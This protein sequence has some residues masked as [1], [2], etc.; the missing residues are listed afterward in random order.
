MLE[1]VAAT[2]NKDK[3]KEI[4]RI[5]KDLNVRVLTLDNF[6]KLPQVI[7]SGKTLEENASKKARV[8]SRLIKRFTIADDSGLEVEAL[9]GRPGVR[10][11]RFAGNKASYSE[12]NAKLLRMLK[13]LPLSKRKAGFACAVSIAK[14]GKVLRTVRGACS[15]RI[16]FTLKG[17][18]G[19]GYDPLFIVPKY[20]KTF[21]QLGPKVKN[22]ISHRYKAL[23]KA[24]K[25]LKKLLKEA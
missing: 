13:G 24:G 10:S 9:N 1:V 11:S 4:K 12:N 19:F 22:R 23:K 17:K 14:N 20:G 3:A 6:K 21:A 2:R 18:S 16:G 8:I 15:G 7:E 5:L 25:I